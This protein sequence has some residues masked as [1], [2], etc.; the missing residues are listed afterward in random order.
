MHLHFIHFQ[1]LFISPS[2]VLGNAPAHPTTQHP[3]DLE[4]DKGERV[5][6]ESM[7]L[8][9]DAKNVNY[10]LVCAPMEA[11]SSS[12][13]AKACMLDLSRNKRVTACSPPLDSC[14]TV[15]LSSLSSE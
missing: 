12:R 4:Q 8:T 7:K 3:E 2:G 9:I 15:L 1:S 14:T 5:T 11:N 6:K 10:T 13:K